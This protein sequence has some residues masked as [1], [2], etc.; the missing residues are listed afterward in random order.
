VSRDEVPSGAYATA[1]HRIS[2]PAKA[3]DKRQQLKVAIAGIAKPGRNASRLR[4]CQHH[5]GQERERNEGSRLEQ[6]MP[7]REHTFDDGH[8]SPS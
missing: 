6:S 7:V 5:D 8:E 2:S 4:Q 1:A 3:I